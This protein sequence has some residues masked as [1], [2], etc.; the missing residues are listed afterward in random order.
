MSAGLVMASIGDM[1]AQSWVEKG[2]IETKRNL[3]YAVYSFFEVGL[4][5]FWLKALDRYCGPCMGMANAV[6][7]T[8]I[9]QL[10]FSAVEPAAG[11]S[12]VH[13]AKGHPEPLLEKLK[14]DFPV[15]YLSSQVLSVPAS[16]ICFRYVP[17][18][19]RIMFT[20]SF[21]LI[22]DVYSSYSFSNNLKESVDSNLESVKEKYT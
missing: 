2:G 6:R 13:M 15:F 14:R 3:V 8:I 11:M 21:S 9:D 19:W 18:N 1:V 10:T 5:Y 17:L 7:K 12:V 22:Y 20:S 16:L 4:E